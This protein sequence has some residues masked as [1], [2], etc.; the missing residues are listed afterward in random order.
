[1]SSSGGKSS[2][3]FSFAAPGGAMA[4][5]QPSPGSMTG[6]SSADATVMTMPT[7]SQVS[8]EG[9]VVHRNRLLDLMREWATQRES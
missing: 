1:M 6:A 7:G 3:Q 8:G 5:S 4:M 2:E 9:G